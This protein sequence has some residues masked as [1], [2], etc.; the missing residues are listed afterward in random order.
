MFNLFSSKYVC[1]RFFVDVLYKVKEVSSISDG[2]KDLFY[3]VLTMNG[4]R[5]LS[6]NFSASIE[7]PMVLL[8]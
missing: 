3:F 4:Y 8:I 6:N 2:I 7:N 1:C 5:I